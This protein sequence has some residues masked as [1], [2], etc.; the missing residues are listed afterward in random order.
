[1]LHRL[2]LPAVV[3]LALVLPARAGGDCSTLSI[4]VQGTLASGATVTIDVSGATALAPT[5]LA[6]G[7]TAGSTSIP[8]GPLGTLDL[9][10]ASPFSVAPLGMTD[11]GGSVSTSVALPP[12]S[13]SFDPISGFAQAVSIGIGFEP[14]SGVSLSFC[15]SNVDDFTIS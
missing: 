12:A 9:G 7:P 6:V 15:T 5:L 13:V 2:S 4:D 3:A 1:M 11:A 8:L 10:L 14:G